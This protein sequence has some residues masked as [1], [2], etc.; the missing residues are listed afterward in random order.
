MKI[1][2]I[3]YWIASVES[4]STFY[5]KSREAIVLIGERAKRA[6]RAGVVRIN[7]Y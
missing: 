2:D 6:T 1:E 7:V 5:M 3:C 4:A